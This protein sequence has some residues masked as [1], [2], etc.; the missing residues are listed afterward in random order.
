MASILAY[1]CCGCG[2]QMS[3]TSFTKVTSPWGNKY[4][5][6]NLAAVWGQM[7]TGGGYNTKLEESMSILG[8][9]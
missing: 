5:T 2:D 7:A 9:L 4:W 6:C 8:M 3:F 1:Q